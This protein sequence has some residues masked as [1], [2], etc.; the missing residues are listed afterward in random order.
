MIILRII[1]LFEGSSPD[2]LLKKF[3]KN[4][5]IAKKDNEINIKIDKT[6]DKNKVINFNK[7]LSNETTINKTNN[8][9]EVIDFR[10]FVDMFFKNREGILH[11][12]LYNDVTLISFRDGEVVLNTEKINDKSFNRNVAKLISTWTGRIWQVNSSTSNLGKSLF[13]EDIINQQKEIEIMK[14]NNQVKKL[15]REFPDSAIHSITEL[16]EVNSDDDTL[17]INMKKEK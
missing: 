5:T 3:E 4:E 14:N 12:K 8:Y 7:E 10:H 13:E 17:N 16:T 6:N 15:L 2:D 9:K 11:T 1:Y